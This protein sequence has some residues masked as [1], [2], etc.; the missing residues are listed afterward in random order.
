MGGS[1]AG[2]AAKLVNNE[3][4]TVFSAITRLCFIEYINLG[5]KAGLKLDKMVE[6]WGAGVGGPQLLDSVGLKPWNTPEEIKAVLKGRT[7]T[8][9]VFYDIDG[10]TPVENFG[11]MY[12]RLAREMAESEGAKVPVSELTDELKNIQSAYNAFHEVLK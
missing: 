9:P 4:T 2:Q 11:D 12:R 5:L 6:V 7:G 3:A 8:M 10:K 1:G